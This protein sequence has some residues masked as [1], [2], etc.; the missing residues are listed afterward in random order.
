MR[1][2]Q[3]EEEKE[4]LDDRAPMSHICHA[5]VNILHS[6]QVAPFAVSRKLAGDLRA[7]V[8]RLELHACFSKVL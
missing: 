8:R 5:R 6:K 1:K 4:T 3:S 7:H 2:Y